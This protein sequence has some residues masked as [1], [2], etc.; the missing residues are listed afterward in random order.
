MPPRR[1]RPPLGAVAELHNELRRVRLGWKPWKQ[2]R[3]ENL[4]W[5]MSMRLKTQY[6]LKKGN[7]HEMK[8]LKNNC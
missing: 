4:T 6:L 5:D 1:G 7:P 2:L 8:Q 3:G